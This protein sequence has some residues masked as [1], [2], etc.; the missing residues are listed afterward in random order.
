VYQKPAKVELGPCK[1][2]RTELKVPFERRNDAKKLGCK[3]DWPR[4]RWYV[5]DQNPN[6]RTLIEIYGCYDPPK[7][8]A[9]AKPVAKVNE[10]KKERQARLRA[11]DTLGPCWLDRTE[12]MVDIKDKDAAKRDGAKWNFGRPTP[13]KYTEGENK[14]K[15]LPPRKRWCIMNDHDNCRVSSKRGTVST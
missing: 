2:D 6:R 8:P 10:T 14:G 7:E 13:K 3:F 4:R 11:E 12:L 5:T 1:P 9:T 15:F